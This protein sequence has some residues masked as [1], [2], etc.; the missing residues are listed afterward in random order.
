MTSSQ[1]RA[2]GLA[3]DE[4]GH[5]GGLADS[6]SGDT[7]LEPR[8]LAGRPDIAAAAPRLRVA[9]AQINPTV[10][11]LDGNT[12]KILDYIAR[13]RD[14]GA[15]LV[16]FPE[17][18][19]TGYPPEDLLLKPKFVQDNLECLQRVI[20]AS[21]DIVVV[22]GFVDLCDDLRNSAA[23][24]QNSR[25]LGVYHKRYLP[26]YGVFDEDRYFARGEIAP[27][28]A[29]GSVMIGANICED[30]WYPTGPTALQS[31]QGAQ[32]IINISGSPY[33]RGKRASRE[34]MLATRAVDNL[35]IVAYVNL[36]GGQDELVF[37]GG[38]AIF[39]QHGDVI[40]RASQFEED[41]LVADLDVSAVLRAQLHD[42]RWRKERR[43]LLAEREAGPVIQGEALT[44]DK[45]RPQ[46]PA[47]NPV[48]YEP[49][50][51]AEIY[52][53]LVVGTRDY[54]RKNGFSK[55]VLG[56][57]GGIDSS[58][59]AVIAAD[60]LG[61]ENVVAVAMP[62]RYSSP[63][64]LE[65]AQQLAA[66][67][68]IKLVSISI[69]PAFQAMLD[70]LSDAFRGTKPGT[71]E[72]N[73]QARIRGNIV[74]ALSNKFGYLV[75][76][77]GNKS[78]YAVGYATLYGDMAGGLAVLKDVYKTTVYELARYRNSLNRVIPARV[79][80]KAPSAELRPHQL[81]TD[82]LPPYDVLDRV[83][84][85]YVEEDHSLE[86]II[87]QGFDPETVKR[88][89]SMVDHS[90]Y[91]RRQAAPGIRVTQRAFGRDRRLPITNRYRG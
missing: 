85:A 20:A 32:V 14:L 34:R 52:A 5:S 64:S 39:D 66:A 51:P 67:L 47:S 8:S 27:V 11:D 49:G 33:H 73:V 54:A 72:E 36:V 16:A 9:L 18:A 37:D 15:D 29:L 23:V 83:L 77:T 69:E 59:T 45:P 21:R 31:A 25:L 78:E 65:D 24:I 2:L 88:T 89:V 71:A 28:F 42:P 62:S 58:L 10:G 43:R 44:L 1:A 79:I 40:A 4:Q 84:Q 38:S 80:E 76:A 70:M 90:E 82:S 3:Q 61:P 19:I 68:G 60:A 30:M 63:A 6:A 26:T 46:L 75:L 12:A 35:S 53:A 48:L 55:V 13:A 87:K 74:M 86:E 50:S 22:V 81:D 17:L 91:K 7:Q 56:L 57:S 41:L